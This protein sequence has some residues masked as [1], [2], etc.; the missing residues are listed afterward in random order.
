MK[1]A[2]GEGATSEQNIGSDQGSNSKGVGEEEVSG[3]GSKERAKEKGEFKGMQSVFSV[4][5]VGFLRYFL[6]AKLWK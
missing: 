2:A 4:V 3:L 5:K 1:D 6:I